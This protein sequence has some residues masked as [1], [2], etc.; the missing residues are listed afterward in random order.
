MILICYDGSE[1]AKAAADYA[2]R[3]LRNEPATVV[4]VREPY[5]RML[6]SAGLGMGSG[7]GLNYEKTAHTADVQDR[8]RER[9]QRI[10]EEGA[11]RLRAAG[12]D[13]DWRVEGRDG[14]VAK[15]ILEVARRIGAETVVVGTRGHGG[16]TSALLGR[17][18]HELVAHADRAVVVVPSPAHAQHRRLAF[19]RRL[20]RLPR[21]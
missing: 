16:A 9:D 7:F 17:V 3:L 19:A 18:P 4:T 12:V 11:Q 13:A 1:D 21:V 6:M 20:E 8:L 10:A 2:A 15:T 5:S 14:S